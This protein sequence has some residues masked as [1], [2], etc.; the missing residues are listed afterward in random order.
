MRHWTESPSVALTA[1]LAEYA[2]H[3]VAH[4]SSS[5][6]SASPPPQLFAER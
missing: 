3:A 6:K 2:S 1:P 5:A 4:S